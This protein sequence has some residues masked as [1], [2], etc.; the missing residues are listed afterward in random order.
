MDCT[1][2][3]CFICQLL[4]YIPLDEQNFNFKI[5][6]HSAPITLDDPHASLKLLFLQRCL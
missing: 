1:S 5:V 3:V 6:F 4:R 2:F